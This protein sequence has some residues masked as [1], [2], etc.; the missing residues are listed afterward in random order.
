M[1]R[2]WAGKIAMFVVFATL[3]VFIMGFVVMRLWNWLLPGLFGFPMIGF[4]QA[5]GVLILS[6][7]LFGGFHGR[8]SRRWGGGRHM[9]ARWARMSPEERA[10][11]REAM[12][13]GCG[14]FGPAVSEPK[15]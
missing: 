4:W 5:A 11:F 1:K 12:R 7:L 13:G 3:F 6:R 8:S 9:V 2:H 10:K 14:P 15:Q